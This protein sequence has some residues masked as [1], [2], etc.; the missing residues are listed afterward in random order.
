MCVHTKGRAARKPFILAP[1]QRDD[2]VRPLFGTLRYDDQLGEWVRQYR[3]AWIE[4]GRKNGKSELA[5]ALALLG[6]VGDDEESAEVYSVAADRDQASLVF[7]TAK[8]MVEPSPVLSR[9]LEAID[10]RKRIVDRTTN[11]FYAVL[12]GDAAGALGVNAS[13][14]LLDEVLTQ[15][16]R[17]LYDAMRQSFGTRQQP[18]IICVTTAA[19]TSA[20][21]A[22]EEHESSLLV[23][24]DPARD[25]A[26][27]V[28][29]RNTPSDA[30]WLDEGHRGIPK[31][32]SRL[33]VGTTPI[34]PWVTSSTSTPSGMKRVRH[35]TSHRRKTPF[36]F[37]GS[38]SG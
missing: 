20:A 10:S 38:T 11:S 16:D 24:E 2:I 8:R 1:W 29:V 9:R 30:D 26:R 37:S 21:F 28:Y 23:A 3:T 5:S 13:M 22:L 17:H 36:G 18:L 35:A 27:F 4:L 19:Y 34:R 14:V 12:P 33:R 25:P 6:L 7:N 15:R 31:R 32:G